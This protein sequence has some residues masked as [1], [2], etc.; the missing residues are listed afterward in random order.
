MSCEEEVISIRKQLE[1]ITSSQDTTQALDLLKALGKLDINLNILTNTRI[2]MT[3]NA[4]R[5]SSTDEETQTVA[6]SLI[7]AW[8]KLVPESNDKK[9]EKQR[10]E[11]SVRREE[12]KASS[13]PSSGGLSYSLDE[14]RSSCRKLLLNAIKGEGT[15]PEGCSDEKCQ[16]I[17]TNLEAAIFAQYKQTSPKYKNQ[18]RSRVFNLKDKKNPMLRMNLLCGILS[19][20]RLAKMTSEE[21]AN[22][23]IKKQREAFIKE[24]INDA[25]LAQVEGTKTDMLKCGKCGKNNCTYNQIQTRSAD[26]PMT[27]FVLCNECG[28]RWK[29]C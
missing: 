1:K 14:V 4:L 13:T 24:G 25:Q 8:K 7:K 22:D 27:T 17:A 11:E 9:E 18:V 23:E 10:K 5:K 26:E 19:A 2:G 6:K 3:V 28:N 21:M 29:F 16:D 20:E 12:K 15:L